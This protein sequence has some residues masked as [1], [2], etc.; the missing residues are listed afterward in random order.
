MVLNPIKIFDGAFCGQTLWENSGYVTPCAKRSMLKKMKAG[1]YQSKLQSKAAY[2]ASRPTEPTY[3][4]DETEDVFQ[5]L[6]KE[7]EDGVD[8]I[9]EKKVKKKKMKKKQ[10]KINI[11]GQGGDD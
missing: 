9:P 10:P 2:E 5:T 1:K 11:E 6:E 3:K 7:A 4:V 8:D